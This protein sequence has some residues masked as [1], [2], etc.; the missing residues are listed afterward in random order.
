MGTGKF[1]QYGC[2][3]ALA[4]L[5][6]ACAGRTPAP[7]STSQLSDATATCEAMGVEIQ[8]NNQRIALL[9]RQRSNTTAKNVGAVV[10][11][12]LFFPPLML[13][14]DLSGAD[15]VELQALQS[16]NLHL[17]AL[18]KQKNC[19]NIP[20]LTPDAARAQEIDKKVKESVKGGEQPFC[21]DVGG[22]EEYKRRTGEICRL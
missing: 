16:R 3:L 4:S 7:V 8:S 12:V 2:A 22:Y 19:A 10:V 6:A 14:M 18:M 5:M 17:A 13:A 21:K 1:L 15:G 20:A 11:G 9:D